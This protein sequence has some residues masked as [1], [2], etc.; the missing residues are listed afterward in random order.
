M[1]GIYK[2]NRR[3]L[4]RVYNCYQYRGK[5]QQKVH[6]MYTTL[7][8]ARIFSMKR[9]LFCNINEIL[10]VHVGSREE[11]IGKEQRFLAGTIQVDVV[12]PTSAQATI[13]DDIASNRKRKGAGGGSKGKAK[14]I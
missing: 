12:A 9:V 3:K 8:C 6:A 13:S 7:Y 4:R 1:I 11:M 2:G 14:I 10:D 5:M